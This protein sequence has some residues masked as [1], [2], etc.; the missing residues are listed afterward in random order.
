MTRL[1]ELGGKLQL[2]ANTIGEFDLELVAAKQAEGEILSRAFNASGGY[3]TDGSALPQ[4]SEAYKKSK[5]FKKRKTGS[6]RWNLQLSDDL[7]NSVHVV[8]RGKDVYVAIVGPTEVVKAEG[9]EERAG[10]TIFELSDNE[11]KEVIKTTQNIFNNLLRKA[12]NKIF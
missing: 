12:I 9:L 8:E 2:L 11:R 7:I 5:A 1:E 4:Y 10:K 3:A 6:S